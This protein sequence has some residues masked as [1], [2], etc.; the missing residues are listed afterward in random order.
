[1]CVFDCLFFVKCMLGADDNASPCGAA[2]LLPSTYTPD[3]G[4][5]PN[6]AVCF[7]QQPKNPW[8]NLHNAAVELPAI[9]DRAEG[10]EVQS[11]DV[12]IRKGDLAIDAVKARDK[13]CFVFL[14]VGILLIQ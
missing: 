3:S 9:T 6:H 5:P 13:K 8:T 2:Q 10:G 14:A 7:C 4:A 12:R 1:M 11:R